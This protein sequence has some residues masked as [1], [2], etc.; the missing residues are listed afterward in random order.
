MLLGGTLA[1]SAGSPVL[2]LNHLWSVKIASIAKVYKSWFFDHK[3][4]AHYKYE[5]HPLLPYVSF[6]NLSLCSVYSLLENVWSQASAPYM[7]L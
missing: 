3:K 5:I 4:S 7:A 6:L 1:S 2:I